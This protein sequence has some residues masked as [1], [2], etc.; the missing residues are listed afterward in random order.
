MEQLKAANIISYSDLSESDDPIKRIIAT[1]FLTQRLDPIDVK[2]FLTP[3][4]GKEVLTALDYQEGMKTLLCAALFCD[5]SESV[6]QSVQKDLTHLFQTFRESDQWEEE[7]LE[8]VIATILNLSILPPSPNPKY[9][10]LTERARSIIFEALATFCK[11]DSLQGV[12]EKIEALIPYFTIS[13]LPALSFQVEESKFNP[14]DDLS[15]IY[16][17]F[18]L[19]SKI[20]P[21]LSPPLNLI[22][23]LQ[24]TLE[25]ARFSKA[26]SLTLLLYLYLDLK[27]E[28]QMPCEIDRDQFSGHAPPCSVK[29]RGPYSLAFTLQGAKTG[30]GSLQK[31]SVEL[32]SFGPQLSPIS[33]FE[34]F[35]IHSR[36]AKCHIEREGDRITYSG[37]TQIPQ[38]TDRGFIPGPTA[39]FV[40]CTLSEHGVNLKF[41]FKELP[42][43][44]FITFY[45]KGEKA[46]IDK[47]TLLPSSLD[48]FEGKGRSA[49]FIDGN[50]SLTL[51]TQA[52][53]YEVIPLAGGD[54]FWSANFLCAI[55]VDKRTGEL[56]V[57]IY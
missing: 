45:F 52:P 42:H 29:E 31:G 21:Q 56:D 51:T 43:D 14:I 41:K 32:I 55:P 16:L 49:E 35:G 9:Q 4:K 54:H 36:S 20:A 28:P 10:P 30:L 8:S 11:G 44:H 57:K 24:D 5:L 3:L 7:A 2:A 48:R 40:A 34:T 1:I 46:I 50:H 38:M 47:K 18:L 27:F 19:R 15:A 39:L 53:H 37:W 25:R 13:K 26:S 6:K 12:L 17:L 22:E 23:K 33:A